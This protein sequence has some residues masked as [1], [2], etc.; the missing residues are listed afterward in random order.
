MRPN[1]AHV[2]IETL[3]GAGVPDSRTE[4][5]T[6]TNENAYPDLKETAFEVTVVTQNI[7]GLHQAAAAASR[8]ST[9]T[10]ELHGS[11]RRVACLERC[12][13]SEDA[14][15]F[16]RLWD[17]PATRVRE[18]ARRL[19]AEEEEDGERHA[20]DGERKRRRKVSNSK[21]T[22]DGNAAVGSSRSNA[23][24]RTRAFPTCGGCGVAPAK[25][26]CVFFGE[27]LPDAAVKA[28]RAACARAHAV[29]IVGTSLS[30]FPAADLPQQ[31]RVH[32]PRAPIVRVDAC[33][34]ATS[35]VGPDDAVITRRAA[36]AVP[37]LV[38]R[39]LELRDGS[40]GYVAEDAEGAEGGIGR[41]VASAAPRMFS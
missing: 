30:V 38:R 28:A 41:P 4:T 21:Q 26:A 40:R 25:P 3:A 22:S 39:V 32:T 29:V 37:A 31:A 20:A 7:D 14:E 13:W 2:A 6:K 19:G 24:V 15:T 27:A 35:T 8:T 33:A 36:R 34:S 16:L 17:Q 11:T 23:R 10:I 18:K 12:G 9:R 5:E 1:D